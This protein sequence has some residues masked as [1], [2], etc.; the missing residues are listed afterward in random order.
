MISQ[1]RI[2]LE[3]N[4]QPSK[5]EL[6]LAPAGVRKLQSL[7]DRLQ[8]IQDVL[9]ISSEENTSSLHTDP[10]IVLPESLV[11]KLLE[12]T[13]SQYP[14]AHEG[15]DKTF[16]RI[17]PKY[18]WPGMRKDIKLFVETCPVCDKFKKAKTPRHPLGQIPVGEKLD[19]L[20][21]DIMGGK[22]SLP[23]SPSGN[24]CILVMVDAFTK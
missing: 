8:E 9:T 13:H 15:Y 19:L 7:R 1:I 6:Q 23:V 17:F 22:D 5:E 18:F 24:K 3:E 12:A 16:A 20:V 21:M 11:D 4:H 14:M 2:W 10:Q